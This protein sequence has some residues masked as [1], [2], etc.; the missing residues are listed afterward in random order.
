MLRKLS[1]ALIATALIAGP[2]LAAAN[3]AGA[4]TSTPAATPASTNA[5]KPAD[6]PIKTVKHQHKPRIRHH[7]VAK[8]KMPRHVKLSAKH[9][10]LHVVSHPRKTNKIV[11]ESNTKNGDKT[12]TTSKVT[13]PTATHG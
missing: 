12:N 8:K 3:S 4:A 10:R 13:K 5:A 1:A 2:A 6:K 9:H 11:K 7:V